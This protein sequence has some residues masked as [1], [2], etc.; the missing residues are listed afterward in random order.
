MAELLKADGESVEVLADHLTMEFGVVAKYRDDLVNAGTREVVDR[1]G[2]AEQETKQTVEELVGGWPRVHDV[3]VGLRS[4]GRFPKAFPLRFP[5]GVADLFDERFWD[6]QP[7][8]WLQHMLRYW[9]GHFVTSRGGQ[10]VVW[11]MVNTVFVLEASKRGFAVYKNVRRRMGW[12]V[13]GL[14]GGEVLTR[15]R[16][17]EMKESD[18]LIRTLVY[19]LTTV[20][21]DLKSSTSY[22]NYEGKKLNAGVH[23]LAWLP[24]WLRRDEEGA[25]QHWALATNEAVED[26]LGH[27]RIPSV[28]FTVNPKFNDA[29]DIHRLNVGSE[30]AIEALVDPND[31]CVAERRR[32]VRDAPDLATYMMTLRTELMM[33]ALMPALLS[34]SEKQRFRSLARAECGPGGNLHFH[35]VGWSHGNPTLGRVE[36]VEARAVERREEEVEVRGTEEA[37]ASDAAPAGVGGVV[38]SS[39]A[40]GGGVSAALEGDGLPSDAAPFASGASCSV[41]ASAPAGDV[42][43]PAVPVP[44]PDSVARAANE[45][46][47]RR[48]RRTSRTPA[49]AA[50]V[51]DSVF[52]FDDHAGARAEKE[53]E[54]ARYFERVV[55][56][57]NPCFD[58]DG[59]ARFQWDDDVGAHN[60]EVWGDMA[61]TCPERVNLRAYLDAVL[62]AGDRG[63]PVDLQPV[64]RLVSALVQRSARHTMHGYQKP[65]PT[66]PC[67]RG[68]PGCEYCRYGFPQERVRWDPQRPS[69]LVQGDRMGQWSVRFPRNDGLCC[70]YEPHLLLCNMGNV[71]WRPCLNLWAVV[72][73]ITK[74]ATKAPSGSKRLGVVVQEVMEELCRYGTDGESDLL[75]QTCSKVFSRNLGGRDIGIL[76]AV[77][78]GLNLP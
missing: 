75:K 20:G 50:A 16:L 18:D 49:D 17:R 2:D 62:S 61:A 39:R 38:A 44:E 66:H 35:G 67:A 40:E 10:R 31:S 34:Q 9:T 53:V 77:H 43:A 5:M 51:A 23:F 41:G 64:R 8:E 12:G 73:Y 1:G 58:E 69:R 46:R 70:S 71:D 72:E 11:A 25:S 54:F 68:K 47:L 52:G 57:W 19:Q 24:P 56:E 22:W 63:E 3:P 48:R 59:N 37:G 7:P 33:C 15:A 78:L 65:K 42:P 27:G 21:R 45:D 55:S 14:G 13:G 60:V 30:F 74:Y 28:W 6:V 36:E 76:E 26:E 32:F 29:Y 4:R